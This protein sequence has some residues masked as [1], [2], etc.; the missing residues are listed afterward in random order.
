MR[1]RHWGHNV[2]VADPGE[3]S[4][5]GHEERQSGPYRLKNLAAELR[6]RRRHL[7]VYR[8]SPDWPGKETALAFEFLNYDR[9]LVIA[10]SMLDVPAPQLADRSPL[11]PEAPAALEDRLA[12][13]G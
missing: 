10:A 4:L 11:A 8:R 6:F 9:R 7:D 1:R 13:G 3:E 12:H 5:D 2:E